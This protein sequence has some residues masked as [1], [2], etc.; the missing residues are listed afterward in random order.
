MTIVLDSINSSIAASEVRIKK[1][2]E[3]LEQVKEFNHKSEAFLDTVKNK[4]PQL[5]NAVK[6]LGL[7]ITKFSANKTGLNNNVWE[8]GDTMVVHMS[9]K[10]VGGKFK[11]FKY[12]RS[13]E[14]QKKLQARADAIAEVINGAIG[15]SVNVNP[16][17]L[18]LDPRFDPSCK[19]V[20]IDFWV[21]IG[22]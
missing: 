14:N 20:L 16:F 10:P 7:E 13:G 8:E 21:G 6:V 4:I 1:Q 12:N 15:C 19:S 2:L 17:S 3:V 9:L 18:E 22:E 5:E 11:F